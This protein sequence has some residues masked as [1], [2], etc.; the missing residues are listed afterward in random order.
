VLTKKLSRGTEHL[1]GK[2]K[3]KE[4]DTLG[5]T[6]GRGGGLAESGFHGVG[7]V[8]GKG[9]GGDYPKKRKET[10]RSSKRIGKRPINAWWQSSS[11]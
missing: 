2:P 10:G 1:K 9:R 11:G 3:Q 8:S 6:P 4:Q 7:K 5:R